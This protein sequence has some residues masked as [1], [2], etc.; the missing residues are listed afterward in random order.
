MNLA[1]IRSFCDQKT[2][3]SSHGVAIPLPE[4]PPAF[5]P[6]L[7]RR[8]ARFSHPKMQ[9]NEAFSR[10]SGRPRSPIWTPFCTGERKYYELPHHG[11]DTKV[12]QFLEILP[13]FCPSTASK[14]GKMLTFLVILS[15]LGC[16]RELQPAALKSTSRNRGIAASG[17]QIDHLFESI[18]TL[19]GSCETPKND[20]SEQK[21]MFPR[22]EQVSSDRHQESTRWN[23]RTLFFQ[24]I[25]GGE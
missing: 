16:E 3:I 10:K 5:F 19:R 7:H 20:P 15:I 24:K 8:I 18:W 21:N 9:E 14:L 17:A 13:L 12:V 22:F 6:S 4:R 11:M 2:T 25:D 1:E 23:C